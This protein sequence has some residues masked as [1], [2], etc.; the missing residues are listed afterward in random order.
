VDQHRDVASVSRVCWQDDRWT[1]YI[2]FATDHCHHLDALRALAD[3]P[4]RIKVFATRRPPEA[5]RELRGRLRADWDWWA[6]HGIQIRTL[7]NDA[8]GDRV[9]IGVAES[10]H[11][12][13]NQFAAHYSVPPDALL[14]IETDPIVDL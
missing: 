1:L 14:V 13:A 11:T 7:S 5:V 10:P 4:D 3:E 6:E 12:A 9:K 2:G 8:T